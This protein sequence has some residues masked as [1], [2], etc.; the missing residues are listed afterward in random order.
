MKGVRVDESRVRLAV[1]ATKRNGAE[2]RRRM[3]GSK[4]AERQLLLVSVGAN[5]RFLTCEIT[6]VKQ[7]ST[8][9]D[10]A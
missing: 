1:S 9:Y 3:M 2:N 5:A 10:A 4:P 8:T 6:E 7:A